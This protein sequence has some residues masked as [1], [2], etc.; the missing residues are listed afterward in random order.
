M[1]VNQ[2]EELLPK[3]HQLQSIM[4]NVATG[5]A[6]YRDEDDTYMDLYEDVDSSISLLHE[7]RLIPSNPNNFKSLQD[8]RIHWKAEFDSYHS[9]RKY[10]YDLYLD[11]ILY[12]EDI[13]QKQAW[14]ISHSELLSLIQPQLLKNFLIDIQKMQSILTEVSTGRGDIDVQEMDYVDLYQR[15]LLS[16]RNLQ[17]YGIAIRNPNS[18]SSLWFWHSYWKSELEDYDSRQK[19]VRELYFGLSRLIQQ[20]LQKYQQSTTLSEELTKDLQNRFNKQLEQQ[21]STSTKVTALQQPLYNQDNYRWTNTLGESVSTASNAISLNALVNTELTDKSLQIDF[22]IITA[23]KV[24]R[25]AVLKAFG[26]DE[27]HD[28]VRM[29]SRT[30]W[31]KRLLLQDGRFYE[32]VVAQLLEAANVNAAITANDV[33]HHWKPMAVLMVGIAATA[34]PFPSQSLGDLVIGREVFYYET[35]KV[36]ATGKLPEPKQVPVDSTL[37]DRVQTLPDCDFPILADRPDGANARPKVEPGVIA[38]GDKVIASAGDR[39]L[40]AAANRKILAIEM[41][42]YGVIEAARQSFSHIRCLVI[43][44]LCDFADSDK[45]DQWHAYAAAVAAGFTNYF[46]LDEP[47]PPSNKPVSRDS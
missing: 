20:S 31:R 17:H 23:I 3:I 15:T 42:G 37:L 39:D 45:H 44:A 24:E 8:W 36:T 6:D 12:I 26:I 46:L 22:A 25:L 35:G 9:R 38:S 13:L 11:F 30:Y 27:R 40:I 19:F 10:I 18:F 4:I 21:H 7:D 32:V 14:E 5:K 43:R 29:G 33:F 1:D 34:K 47:L 16:V 28:R 41:E 2:L